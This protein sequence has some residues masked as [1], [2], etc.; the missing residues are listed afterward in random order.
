MS[1]LK[2][3]RIGSERAAGPLGVRLGYIPGRARGMRAPAQG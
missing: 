2:E 3:K 1:M